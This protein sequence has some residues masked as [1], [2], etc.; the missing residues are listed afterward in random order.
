ME[1][2][3]RQPPGDAGRRQR[4]TTD[5]H[6]DP[7]RTAHAQAACRSP[8]G[9]RNVGS[10]R[11]PT[12]KASST[13]PFR[14]ADQGRIVAQVTAR[15]D[16]R[17]EE[18]EAVFLHRQHQRLVEPEPVRDFLDR[19]AEPLASG[20]QL[21]ARR[22]GARARAHPGFR[23]ARFL[24]RARLARNPGIPSRAGRGSPPPR[25]VVLERELDVVAEQ[26]HVRRRRRDRQ[27]ALDEGPRLQVAAT[28]VQ[29]ARKLRIRLGVV[30]L[31]RSAPDAGSAPPA[32]GGRRCAHRRPRS[33]RR[34]TA[35]GR[36]GS[37]RPSGTSPR[38]SPAACCGRGRSPS[39]FSASGLS[40]GPRARACR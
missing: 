39:A 18:A 36:A 19:E 3:S 31:R 32:R 16:R 20:A 29:Y 40:P 35:S 38:P 7:A 30:D 10:G 14:S 1:S 11:S 4:P 24:R 5:D 25:P 28:L 37:R 22:A 26:Q 15:E 33:C 12:S 13:C 17:A 21:R 27:E 9:G 34:R 23:S 6:G 2:A 8:A